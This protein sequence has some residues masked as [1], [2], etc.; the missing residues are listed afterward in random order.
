MPGP[1]GRGRTPGGSGV[2]ANRR[3]VPPP[4]GRTGRVVSEPNRSRVPNPQ[5]RAPQPRRAAPLRTD[6]T[7]FA[8]GR[9]LL[10]LA[11]IAAGLK[12]VQIQGLEAAELQ[13]QSRKQRVVELAITAERGPILDRNGDALA[14]SVQVKALSARPTVMTDELREAGIDPETR[15]REMA[16]F[17]AATLGPPLLEQQL[18]ELLSSDRKFVYLAHDVEP[19]KARQITEKYPQ[20]GSEDREL[21]MY[22]GGE[23]AANL[24]GVANWRMDEQQLRG[25]AGLENSRDSLLAGRNGR[26]LVDTAANSDAIIPGSERGVQ[27]AV[28]GGGLQLTIDADLQYTLQQQLAAAVSASGAKGA[29]AVVLDAKTAQVYALANDSTFD[30]SDRSS[31]EPDKMGNPAIAAPFEPGSVNKVVTAAAAIEYGLVTP[32]TVLEVPSS[33]RFADRVIRD[34]W[35]HGSINL[36]FTG[37]L[38]KSSNVGTLMTAKQVGED[39]Y[40][41]MLSRFGLGQGTEVG[42]P[43]ESAGRVPPRSEWSGSTFGNLPIGQGLSMTVLQMAG[44]YQTIANDGVRVP[45]RIV[46]AE[47][48]ANGQRVEAPR[49]AGIRVVSEPTART[50]RDMLRSVVQDE[51]GQRGTAPSA[52]LNG[53]QV[54]GKTGTGQ[55]PDPA[56]GC[57]SDDRHWITF[58]GMFPADAP[59]FVIG[60]VLDAPSRGTSAGPVFHDIASYLAQRYQVPLSP[61]PAPI[62]QLQIR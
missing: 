44:M 28:P 31:F 26:R 61:T 25:L 55:Q 8:L 15:K 20:I 60:I 9:M 30:P 16:A 6:S 54:A 56:C 53:Y 23:L 40:A 48:D 59:R 36:T 11:L 2:P 17:M 12:L 4:R 50:V 37:V 52:A 22:P 58:A 46:A 21:R 45:P 19:G 34:A 57:Y 62:M 51:P 24:I 32:D 1:G 38:G 49:P 41:D 7:R 33:I 39:R 3:S 42:L 18:L 13:V 14:F 27:P 35:S 29:S 43:G 10:V 5:P 47:I